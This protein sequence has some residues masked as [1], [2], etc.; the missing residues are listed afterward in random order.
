MNIMNGR[1]AIVTG[2][3]AGIGYAIAEQ[4]ARAGAS[5]VVNGR[6]AETLKEAESGIEMLGGK[7]LGIQADATNESDIKTI[8][9]ETVGYFGHIDIL[10]NNAATVGVGY[11]VDNMPNEVWTDVLDANL[12]SVFLCCKHAI[13]QIKQSEFGRIINIGGLSGKNPLPFAAADAVSKAGILALTRVLAAE[14]G[15]YN[16]TVNTV[17]P[18]FQPDT[19]TGKKFNEGLA[20]AFNITPKESIEATRSRTLLKRFETL[21]EIA[22]TVLF[23]CSDAGGAITGQD[24]NVN[25]GLATH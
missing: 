4:L 22:K 6:T 11:S 15:Y 1:V 2:S 10:I 24:L 20:E 13:P 18:G 8:I 7:V 21:D 5:V 23:L 9:H 16:V 12:T 17:I 14:L 19:E 3:T 25:C